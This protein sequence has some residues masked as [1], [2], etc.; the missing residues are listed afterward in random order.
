MSDE[1]NFHE[2]SARAVDK[3]DLIRQQVI[4]VTTLTEHYKAYLLPAT[5][6]KGREYQTKR[7][8][9]LAEFRKISE[10]SL[11]ALAILKTFS[12]DDGEAA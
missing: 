5:T 6:L 9:L 4:L 12:P 7:D 8:N 3:V 11:A 10:A 1:L 2:W